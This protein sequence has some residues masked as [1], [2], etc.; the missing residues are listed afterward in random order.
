MSAMSIARICC[1]CLLVSLATPSWAQ[2]D[3][4]NMMK[5]NVTMKIQV[6]GAGTMPAQTLTQNVCTSADHDMRAM[7]QRQKDCTV[8]DYRQ[9][10][11]V[12][13]Y[14]MSCGGTPPAMTG[15]AHFELLPGG[16]IKGSIH[17]NSRMGDQ[18]AVMDM[19]YAGERTGSCDYT[20]SQHA[21]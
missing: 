14:H 16:D 2:S 15:D 8:S 10:G 18:S 17:A 3:S 4:G 12:Y 9:A 20:A 11:N 19:T 13:S 1:V 7:L 21:H 6:P 5:M